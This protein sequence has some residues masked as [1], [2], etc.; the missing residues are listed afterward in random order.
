[1]R[2]M[3]TLERRAAVQGR[4]FAIGQNYTLDGPDGPQITDG[5]ALEVLLG[6][7]WISGRIKQGSSR[8]AQLA[9]IDEDTV[10]EASEESFPASDPPAWSRTVRSAREAT[11]PTSDSDTTYY[12]VAD[13]DNNV[14]G[15]CPGMRVRL[16]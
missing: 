14:C 11:S 7:H 2:A 5:K 6:G 8:V 16:R 3:H 9:G 12:F 10:E 1:M 15:L 4:L 13:A